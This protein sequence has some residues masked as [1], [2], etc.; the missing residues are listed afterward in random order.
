MSKIDDAFDSLKFDIMAKAGLDRPEATG[1]YAVKCPVCN[2][3]SSKKT[4]GFKLESDTIGYNCFRAGCDASTV[5]QKGEFV[6]KKFKS[7][8]RHYGVDVPPVLLMAKK[9]NIQKTMESLD[10]ELYTKNTYRQME[11]GFDRISLKESDNAYWLD[12]ME[13]RYIDN[14]DDMF[15]ITSGPYK[16]LLGIEMFYFDK[17]IGF[18]ILTREGSSAK[19]ITISDNVSPIFIPGHYLK[20]KV[21]VVE[22]VLDAACFPNTVALLNGRISKEQAFHLKG[23]DVIMLPDRSGNKFINQFSDYGWKIS[24][25]DWDVK[26]LNAAVQRYGHPVACQ[27]IMDAVYSN[28]DVAKTKYAMWIEK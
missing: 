4:G 15:Y 10:E 26:D 6:P 1:F 12:M 3:A 28:T 22:G 11:N 25:P 7:L 19:Y 5:Y 14:I 21:L 17:L 13:D 24:L 20:Q 16:G 27:M 18:Q 23:R 8:L 9:S 2:K